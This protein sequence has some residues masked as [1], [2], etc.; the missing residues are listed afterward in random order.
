M[1]IF[2]FQFRGIFKGPNQFLMVGSIKRGM[3]FIVS[4]FLEELERIFFIGEI[5]EKKKG[6]SASYRKAICSDYK[7]ALCIVFLHPLLPYLYR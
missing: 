3:N 4:V 1:Y 5:K 6:G 7:K 2:S